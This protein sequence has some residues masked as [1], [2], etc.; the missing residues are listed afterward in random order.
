MLEKSDMCLNILKSI[1]VSH[2]LKNLVI[3]LPPFFAGTITDKQ[4]LIKYIYVFIIFSIATFIVYLF[5][6]L[7][8]IKSDLLHPNKRNRP[9]ASGKI[10]KNI[11]IY[12]I[13]IFTILLISLSTIFLNYQQNIAI[14]LY[15]ILNVIYSSF[16][17]K[18]TNILGAIFIA[19]VFNIRVI[20]GYITNDISFDP[21]LISCLLTLSIA[22]S[23]SKYADNPEHMKSIENTYKVLS[24]LST[25]LFIL[26]IINN[27]FY[28]ILAGIPLIILGLYRLYN[29]IFKQKSSIT[30]FEILINDKVL[31]F[32]A[33][34]LLLLCY[35]EIYFE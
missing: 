8:D 16:L 19:I 35:F 32:T 26:F 29:L 6:D 24:L 22:I 14:F 21:L 30:P 12:L 11:A 33:I 4:V 2:T 17:K 31:N 25:I 34:S 15:I 9:I 18:K 10:K 1:R 23:L 5:N 20:I 13:C 3:L 28:I 7:C 27:R